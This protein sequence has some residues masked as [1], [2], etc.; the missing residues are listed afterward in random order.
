DTAQ[1]QVL[2]PADSPP[3]IRVTDAALDEH[4][5]ATVELHE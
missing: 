1:P 2:V 5:H 3:T 4:P